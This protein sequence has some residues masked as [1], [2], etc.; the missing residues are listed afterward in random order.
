MLVFK[1]QRDAMEKKLKEH[2]LDAAGIKNDAAVEAHTQYIKQEAEFGTE[3]SEIAAV[4]KLPEKAIEEVVANRG[5][6]MATRRSEGM[7]R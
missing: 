6:L 5:T 7:E 3:L 2:G 4:V 1:T